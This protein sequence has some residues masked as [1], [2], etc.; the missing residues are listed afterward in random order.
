L[1]F[2]FVFGIAGLGVHRLGVFVEVIRLRKEAIMETV[3]P[4]EPQPEEPQPKEPQ[5]GKPEE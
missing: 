2:G 3:P 1:P 4:E 5:P